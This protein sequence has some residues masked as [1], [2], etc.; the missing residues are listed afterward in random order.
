M[1][2]HDTSGVV[3]V[4]HDLEASFLDHR[5][6]FGLLGEF[7]DTFD[8]ILVRVF[9]VGQEPSHDRDCVKAISVVDLLET[10]DHDI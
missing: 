1:N 8:E 3:L 2:C 7:S 9:I 6:E 10:R 4:G 5:G